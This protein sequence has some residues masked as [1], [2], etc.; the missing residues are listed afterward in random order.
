[1]HVL[2]IEAMSEVFYKEYRRQK[3]NLGPPLPCPP[4]RP[5]AGPPL[6]PGVRPQAWTRPYGEPLDTYVRKQLSEDYWRSYGPAQSPEF[7]DPID[8]GNFTTVILKNLPLGLTADRLVDSLG[9][10]GFCGCFDF[11]LLKV[12]FCFS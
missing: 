1:M 10:C 9:R 11:V 4:L 7:M 12:N 8:D 6:P 2:Q 3:Y 5:A